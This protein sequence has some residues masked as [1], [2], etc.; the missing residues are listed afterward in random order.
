MKLQSLMMMKLLDVVTIHCI[1]FTAFSSTIIIHLSSSDPLLVLNL[2]LGAN[3]N[4]P[5]SPPT[6]TF[7]RE[8]DY[9]IFLFLYHDDKQQRQAS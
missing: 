8:I 6:S 5:V 4:H 1:L 9:F 3:K 2:F 7:I